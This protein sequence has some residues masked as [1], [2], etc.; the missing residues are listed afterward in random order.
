MA[1][2]IALGWHGD[3]FIYKAYDLSL[4]LLHNQLLT[5]INPF[6]LS[7]F[8]HIPSYLSS[9]SYVYLTSSSFW[10]LKS[11]HLTIFQS[12]YLF[13]RIPTFTSCLLLIYHQLFIDRWYFY[14]VHKRLFLHSGICLDKKAKADW[15]TLQVELRHLWPLPSPHPTEVVGAG[16]VQEGQGRAS[17]RKEKWWQTVATWVRDLGVSLAA[18]YREGLCLKG[19]VAEESH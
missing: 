12:S 13:I 14:T 10:V 17:W 9:I 2:R 7:Q 5:C 15:K 18:W 4:G 19:P 1:A 3:L 6:I 11:P 16:G 8:C